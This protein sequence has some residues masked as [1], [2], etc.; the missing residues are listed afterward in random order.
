MNDMTQTMPRYVA[1]VDFGTLDILSNPEPAW[2]QLYNALKSAILDGTYPPRTP[3]PTARQIREESGLARATIAKAYDRL[4]EDGL[5]V[6]IPGR[7]A[8][9]APSPED[10]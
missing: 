10:S 7:G 8:F 5:I 1:G 3:M 6:M 9:V 2:R 4:Q